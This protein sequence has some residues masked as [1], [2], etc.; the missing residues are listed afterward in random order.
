MRLPHRLQAQKVKSQGGAGVYCGGDLAAQLVTFVSNVE[1][2]LQRRH[3]FIIVTKVKL[4]KY[5][6]ISPNNDSVVSLSMS[7]CACV[8]IKLQKQ[9]SVRLCQIYRKLSPNAM[10][11]RSYLNSDFP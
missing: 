10:E 1:L 7:E 5:L 6:C 11:G 8:L 2:G 9:Q 4:I 3:D